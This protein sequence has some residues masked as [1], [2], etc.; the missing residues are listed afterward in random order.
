MSGQP[1]FD[2]SEGQRR[3]DEGLDRIEG[4]HADFVPR[5]REAATAYC[6]DHGGVHIDDV[7]RMAAALGLQPRH[8]NAWGAIFRGPGW[9]R[10][11]ARASELTSNHR[12]VSPVWAWK[13][14]EP[15][16]PGTAPGKTGSGA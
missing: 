4:S 1:E 8:K 14:D 10:I 15:A 11:G 3:K 9:Y 5:M 16:M 13:F 12:H 7:R 2:F 6:L